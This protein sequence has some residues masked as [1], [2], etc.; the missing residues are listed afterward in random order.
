MNL[1]IEQK[2]LYKTY[3][4]GINSNWNIDND[5]GDGAG[6]R[7]YNQDFDPGRWIGS[8]DVDTW[9]GGTS[10]DWTVGW[11]W[12]SGSVPIVMKEFGF[13]N[14]MAQIVH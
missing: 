10:G 8:N 13:D 12:G 6:A 5:N 1:K 2:A 7:G 4:L 9:I 11:N 14:L 3:L